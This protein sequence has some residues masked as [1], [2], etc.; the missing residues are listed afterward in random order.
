MLP[1]KSGLLAQ[2]ANHLLVKIELLITPMSSRRFLWML[3]ELAMRPIHD[4]NIRLLISKVNGM[5]GDPRPLP[6][7][8]MVTTTKHASFSE[9]ARR[10]KLQALCLQ[11]SDTLI[12]RAD[13][14]VDVQLFLIVDGNDEFVHN[15]T[16]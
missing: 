8:R 13:V 6:A 15:V 7:H 4:Q 1:I 3:Q 11:S 9:I 10:D 5:L 16:F 12:K 14:R 2:L